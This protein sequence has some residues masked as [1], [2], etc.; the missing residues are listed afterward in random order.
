MKPLWIQMSLGLGDLIILNGLI[1]TLAKERTIFIPCYYN[2]L[3]SAGS[4]F[5]GS[6]IGIIPVPSHEQA[7]A[8]GK[9]QFKDRLLLGFEGPN[10][11]RTHF[12]QSF[13]EQAGLPFSLSWD[14]FSWSTPT[15]VAPLPQKP[16]KFVHSDPERAFLVEVPGPVYHPKG[17]SSIFSYVPALM[18][19]EEFHG[20]DS[21]F[22]L[23]ADRVGYQGKKFLHKYARPGSDNPTYR[24]G[25]TIYEKKPE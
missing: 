10:F 13:Y 21:C 11:D 7:V 19:C 2:N 6:N 25:W 4:M 8:F 20:F 24:N 14:A 1:H 17:Y 18:E 23:L 9:E 3:A 16:A 12:D 5:N 22:A 15:E